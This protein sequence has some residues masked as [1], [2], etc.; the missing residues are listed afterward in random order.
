LNAHLW[1]GV[2]RLSLSLAFSIP[3]SKISLVT[4][5]RE[6]KM[7]ENRYDIFFKIYG[8]RYHV[9]WMILKAQ[10]KAESGFDP[11]KVSAAGARGLAQ[12]MPAVW[13]EWSSKLRMEKASPA[14]PK[15]A[16][17]CQ[18]AYMAWLVDQTGSGEKALAAYKLG[19]GRLKESVETHGEK[20]REHLPDDIQEY[21]TRVIGYFE[22]YR[23]R[24]NNTAS[25]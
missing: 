25:R 7:D 17:E 22:E 3:S 18:A 24:N 20:W 15:R 5:T 9:P 13:Q 12:M 16:L 14:D 23:S 8:D 11:N 6:H 2:C 21:I 10:V 4:K 19:I 1:S